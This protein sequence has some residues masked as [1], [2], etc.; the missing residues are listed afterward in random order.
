MSVTG[1]KPTLR[2][3]RLKQSPPYLDGQIAGMIQR[4]VS[5][6]IVI[7]GIE[8]S[9]IKEIRHFCKISGMKK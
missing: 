8:R 3:F 4:V 9:K 1:I 2:R 5:E 6:H 7:I